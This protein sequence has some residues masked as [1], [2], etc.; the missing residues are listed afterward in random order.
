MNAAVQNKQSLDEW[1]AE[2]KTV[3]LTRGE[4]SA[5][6][7]YIL[8]TTKYRKEEAQAWGKLSQEKNEDGTPKFK[9]AESN[10]QFWYETDHNLDRIRRRIEGC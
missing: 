9:N 1:L 3:T 8:M 10:M 5:L 2:E 6:T 4:W 7:T